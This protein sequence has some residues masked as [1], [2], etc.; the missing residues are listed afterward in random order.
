MSPFHMA[1]IRCT[2]RLKERAEVRGN[3][4]LMAQRDMNLMQ[5]HTEEDD[6]EGEG[7]PN[8]TADNGKIWEHSFSYRGLNVFISRSLQVLVETSDKGLMSVSSFRFLS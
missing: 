2:E 4:M 6:C 5:E 3:G 7:A 1:A 8:A